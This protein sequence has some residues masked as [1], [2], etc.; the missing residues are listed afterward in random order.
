MFSLKKFWI[1]LRCSN[2][3]KAV[4]KLVS[5][6]FLSQAIAFVC[7]LLIARLFSAED[8]GALAFIL[9]ISTILSVVASGRYEFAVMNPKEDSEAARIIATSAC[10][11]ALFII[12]VAL[13]S[14]PLAFISRSE[15]NLSQARLFY[16]LPIIV[17]LQSWF[18][19]LVKW[20]N[21][22]Q[23]YS[24]ISVGIIVQALSTNGMQIFFG[25]TWQSAGSAALALAYVLGNLLAIVVM[26]IFSVRSLR[27]WLRGFDLVILH[28][29]I[30]KYWR[31]PAFTM[32][33]G[34]ASKGVPETSVFFLTAFFGVEVTGLFALT[35]RVLN[36]PINLLVANVGY[37][38]HQR[39][40][41]AKERGTNAA[42]YETAAV[43]IAMGVL[44]IPV[45]AVILVYGESLFS[46]FFGPQWAKAGLFA[47]IMLPAL[48]FR[49]M[50]APVASV[51]LVFN[52]QRNLL[53]LQLLH[54]GLTVLAYW[55]GSKIGSIYWALS[56]HALGSSI[57][58]GLVVLS[59][60]LLS[61]SVTSL[62]EES[63][64]TLSQAFYMRS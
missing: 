5:A 39:I 20:N 53:L 41:R 61:R 43:L 47:K 59:A 3:I 52:R 34:L 13:V 57:A 35:R 54:I 48:V 22:Q 58:Y 32:P 23:Y 1:L 44:M 51:F 46:L 8:F 10:L 33:H 28:Q 37:V 63:Q 6:S 16:F 55:G 40:S 27:S 17:L 30:L 56:F 24:V 11:S 9:S 14:L 7:M 12:I 50:A 29:T 62:K 38:F 42:F 15:G 19:I 31:F 4:G 64:V 49:M 2:Y 21:R 60:L 25:L 26:L 36:Q 18:Q 45:A